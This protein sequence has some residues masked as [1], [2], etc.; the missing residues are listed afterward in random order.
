MSHQDKCGIDCEAVRR[1]LAIAEG[2]PDSAAECARLR[3]M[4]AAC[5][6]CAESMQADVLFRQ[7]LSRRCGEKAPEQ[8]RARVY[9]WFQQTCHTRT[10]V[11]V[12]DD[13]STVVRYT[14]RRHTRFQ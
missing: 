13:G 11:E 14:E 6:E 1:Q 7:M 2:E 5:P 12:H 8:L 9:E 4:L 3:Q 10:S